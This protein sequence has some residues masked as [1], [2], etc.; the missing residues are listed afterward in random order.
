VTGRA[1]PSVKDILFSRRAS[2]CL[3]SLAS[4]EGPSGAHEGGE[5]VE[6]VFPRLRGSV[7]VLQSFVSV[8]TG[9]KRW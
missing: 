9:L 2:A 3:A 5:L 8:S 4:R 1:N 7:V 6:V